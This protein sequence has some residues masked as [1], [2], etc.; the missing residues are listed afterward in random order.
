M[1][2]A[3]KLEFTGE[4]F[5]PECEREIW[6]E[7]YHRYAFAKNL[8]QDKLVLDVASGEGYGSFLLADTA[9]TVTAVD[10]DNASIEHAK[11]KYNKDNLTY[12]LASALELPFDDNHFDVIVSFETLEH[13]AQH[14]EMLAE[15]NRVLKTDGILIISTPD[16]KHY[17][18]DTGFDNE[19]HVKELYKHEFKALLDM[20]W[21]AQK[22]YAQGMAFHSVMQELDTKELNYQ[23]DILSDEM[24]IQNG[25]LVKPMYYV[26]IATQKKQ[27]LPE[28]AS[29]H[30][31]ADES[32]SV[33][34]HY[35]AVIRE[36]IN[37]LNKYNQL[38][39]R[40]QKLIKI[41]LLGRLIKNIL[42]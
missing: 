38:D 12:L 20:H 22:W 14:Q 35:N 6:Y 24:L 39:K 4:R 11:G 8:V 15:F 36:H 40:V 31:F 17:S 18:D 27:N 33:Y 34:G 29:L 5:T 1:T 13:L 2:K 21:P 9:K 41:P 25:E 16:K 10:I 19:F 32:Q 7:H 37:Y 23:L 26:V 30:L 42:K 28:S 3:T